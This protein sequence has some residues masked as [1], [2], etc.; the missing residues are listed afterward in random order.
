M[1]HDITAYT[2]SGK[3]IHGPHTPRYW[4]PHYEYLEAKHHNEGVSGGGHY[5]PMTPERLERALHRV[6]EDLEAGRKYASEIKAWIQ[7][8]RT[9][10]SVHLDQEYLDEGPAIMEDLN[11]NKYD[12][13]FFE[14]M[15]AFLKRC[16]QEEVVRIPFW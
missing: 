7:E 1:G 6:E 14:E 2:R 11:P 8:F 13:I 4:F 3:K 16:I 5:E 10:A 9:K 12:T 15:R